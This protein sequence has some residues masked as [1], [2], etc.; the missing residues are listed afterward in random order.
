M[1][2]GSTNYHI[3]GKQLWI[4][5]W[6]PTKRCI[7]YFVRAPNF[8]TTQRQNSFTITRTK[9]SDI[10]KYSSSASSVTPYPSILTAAAIRCSGC[11]PAFPSASTFLTNIPFPLTPCTRVRK[12][13]LAS[14]S[15]SRIALRYTSAQHQI[16]R[17]KG[18][19]SPRR[20][21][22]RLL[23]YFLVASQRGAS[24]GVQSRGRGECG[25]RRGSTGFCRR[26][27]SPSQGGI[28]LVPR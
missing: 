21:C 7:L 2:L 25:F 28:H 17:A 11:I 5:P 26:W 18:N 14:W 4:N 3:N 23:A 10:Y 8:A 12:R 19:L 15:A 13:D 20:S 6:L 24:P 27:T 1:V 22:A 16:S 9:S